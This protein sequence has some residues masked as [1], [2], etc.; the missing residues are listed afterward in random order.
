MTAGIVHPVPV[1]ELP[2]LFPN[3]RAPFPASVKATRYA[4]GPPPT[5]T[6]T[7]GRAC[8]EPSAPGG[9]S[10]LLSLQREWTYPLPLF[11][12]AHILDHEV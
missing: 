7:A 3:F 12:P 2:R 6:G 10:Q 11:S 8:E 4:G 9:M 1:R 5:L